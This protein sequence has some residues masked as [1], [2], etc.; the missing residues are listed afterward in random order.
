MS[1]A[2][3]AIIAAECR[4]VVEQTEGTEAKIRAAFKETRSS[5]YSDPDLL[6]RGALGAVMLNIG[7]EHPDHK[8]I[9]DELDFI[10]KANAAMAAMMNGLE[11]EMPTIPAGQEL[12][13]IML[14]WREAT[15]PK[16]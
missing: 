7:P 1:N 12:L 2:A 8:R 5:M 10:R 6:I 9:V 16:A 14:M 11:C 4:Q 13:G 3:L 15:N